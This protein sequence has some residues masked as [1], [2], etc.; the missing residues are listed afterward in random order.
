M[1]KLQLFKNKPEIFKCEFNID[2]A[3]VKDTIVRLCLEFSD[4]KNLF[5]YGNLNENGICEINIPPLKEVNHK[6]GKIFI[7]AIADSTYFRVYENDVEIKNSVEIQ[8]VK[9]E[10]TNP[11][12]TTKASNKS[13]ELKEMVVKENKNPYIN[14][15]SKKETTEEKQTFLKKQKS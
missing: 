12:T 3:D 7:E 1:E 13:I 11:K 2:G 14:N 9:A 8:L 10:T 6:E 5:F 15:G 4:N